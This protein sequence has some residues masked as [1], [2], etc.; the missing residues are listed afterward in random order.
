MSLSKCTDGEGTNDARNG[1][2]EGNIDFD[3]LRNKVL[4]LTKHGQVIL[5]LDVFRVRSVQARNEASERCDTD[6]FANTKDTRIDVGRAGF[7]CTVRVRN[8]HT[9]V[10][11]QVNL[12]ITRHNTTEGSDELED[13]SWVCAADGV[14]DAD[15]V[16]ADLVDGLVN[17]K[18]IDE[19]GAE[20]VLGRE[21]DFDALGLDEIDDFNRGLGDIGHIFAVRELAQEGRGADDNVH[22][23][24]A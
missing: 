7:Q 20:G 17:R 14:C 19:V 16:D 4:D 10:V 15:P 9:R 22:T 23:N 2:H 12:N 18:K 3:G 1:I 11:V 6:T 8:C 24:D 21:A 13:L 5:R